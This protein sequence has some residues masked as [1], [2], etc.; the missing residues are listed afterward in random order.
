MLYKRELLNAN[1]VY[2]TR[3]EWHCDFWLTAVTMFRYG[4]CYIPEQLAVFRYSPRSYS[5]TGRR[6]FAKYSDVFS[7][8][9]RLL[10]S[11][12]YEDIAKLVIKADWLFTCPLMVRNPVTAMKAVNGVEKKNIHAN[13]LISMVARDFLRDS[14]VFGARGS[15]ELLIR[16]VLNGAG[17]VKNLGD[18]I[19]ARAF[20]EYDRL[21]KRGG[22]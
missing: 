2:N 13:A 22:A 8:F 1:H 19:F 16:P 3:L 18:Q 15:F 9:M 20:H 5:A 7:E 17:I 14:A 12:E 10:A 6:N 11:P 4:I 21:R